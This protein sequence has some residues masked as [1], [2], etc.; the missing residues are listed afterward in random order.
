M[1]TNLLTLLALVTMLTSS[2]VADINDLRITE[3]W[4][5]RSGPDGTRDWLEVTNTGDTPVNLGPGAGSDGIAYD[6]ESADI[7][8]AFVFPNETLMPGE[9][10]CLLIDI[11]ADNTTFPNSGAEFLAVW[12]PYD[13][14]LLGTQADGGLS[15]NGDS[16][17]LLNATTGAIVDSF[18]Y[19]PAD[20]DTAATMERI[21]EGASDI[22]VSMLGENGAFEAQEFTDEMGNVIL[23]DDGEPVILVGSPGIFEGFGKG[24]LLGDINCDG[25]VDLLDVAPFVDLITNGGFSTKA[26]INLDGVVDLL[27]VAPFINLLTP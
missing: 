27:D 13:A 2:V 4:V 26:D 15:Q 8:V 14:L 17:T 25:V 7:N 3:L 6:D 16:A 21:G 12:V 9:S 11:D 20:T 23:G 5:G 24:G 1:K 19:S 10:L 22:R 18:T